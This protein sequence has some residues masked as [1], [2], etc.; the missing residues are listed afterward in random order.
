VGDG[1]I[2]A[3]E[4]YNRWAEEHADRPPRSVVSP[5]GFDEAVVGRFEHTLRGVSVPMAAGTYPLWVLQRGLDWF[6]AQSDPD[7]KAGR[8]LLQT[9]GGEALLE[10]EF[11]RR[12]TR[13]GSRMALE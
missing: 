7:Q 13:V 3:A 1:I 2:R 11:S 9:C 6:R 4:I 12:L 5:E 10:I 8:E